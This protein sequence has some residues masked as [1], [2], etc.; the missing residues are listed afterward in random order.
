MTARYRSR[1]ARVAAL[2]EDLRRQGQTWAQIAARIAV[3]EHVTM[4]VAFRLAHGLSQREVAAR[5]CEE[6]PAETGTASMSDKIVSYWET[7]PQSGY[8]PSLKSLKRLARIYQC[9]VGD[10]IDNGDFSHLDTATRRTKARSAMAGMTISQRTGFNSGTGQISVIRAGDDGEVRGPESSHPEPTL[11]PAIMELCAVITDCG[12]RPARFCS[13]SREEVPS[14]EDL[15]RDLRIAFDTYQRSKFTAAASRVAMLLADAN[16]TA[17]ECDEADRARVSRVLALSYQAAASVLTK[18]RQ[19]DI[20]WIAA[21]RGFNAAEGSA[22]LPVRASLLRSVAFALHST[23]GLS[24]QWTWWNRAQAACRTRLPVTTPHYLSTVRCS[25]SAPWR[26]LVSAMAAGPQ[27]T[28]RRQTA[29]RNAWAG[30][31]TTFG[32]LSAPLT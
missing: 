20:A 28:S 3:D 19:S 14:S 27:A 7:W 8:E 5:W 30:T 15:E 13:T 26:R 18:V 17:R 12:F 23:G 1:R 32:L 25:W 11:S 10:L 21:E 31:Q 9:N 6:F 24:L 16:L 4:R 2:S 22:S 29:L